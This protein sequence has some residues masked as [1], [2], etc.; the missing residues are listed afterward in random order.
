M[1]LPN[2]IF[3]PTSLP[4]VVVVEVGTDFV[5]I[6]TMTLHIYATTPRLYRC[7]KFVKPSLALFYSA[8]VVH[9]SGNDLDRLLA[10][11][12]LEEFDLPS[13]Q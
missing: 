8:P 6:V 7:R 1:L 3:E 2:V 13:V 4:K 12:G 10:F 5:V 9:N 11:D